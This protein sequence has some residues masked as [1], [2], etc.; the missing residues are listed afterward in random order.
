V[1]IVPAL[2]LAP[3]ATSTEAQILLSFII[4]SPSECGLGLLSR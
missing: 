4:H 3:I 1:V 2:A